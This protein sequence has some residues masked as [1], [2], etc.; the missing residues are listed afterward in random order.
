[1]L[2]PWKSAAAAA[3]ATLLISCG[4]GGGGGGGGGA[5]IG[6]LPPPTSGTPAPTPQPEPVASTYTTFALLPYRSVVVSFSKPN[7]GPG[8]SVEMRTLNAFKNAGGVGRDMAYDAKRDRLYI[9]MGTRI[10]MIPKA[11][12]AS[13]DV[14]KAQYDVLSSGLG[15][16]STMVLD[17]ERDELWLGGPMSRLHG[18]LVKISNISA[19]YGQIRTLES[20]GP[21]ET[22]P[23]ASYQVWYIRSSM[24]M[25]FAIDPTRSLVYTSDGIGGVF[26]LATLT[27]ARK[28]PTGD[29]VYEELVAERNAPVRMLFNGTNMFATDVALDV[30]RNRLYVLGGDGREIITINGASTAN[31]PGTFSRLPLS[32][33]NSSIAVDAKNDRLYV[34]GVDNNAYIFNNASTITAGTVVPGTSVLGAPESVAGKG[35]VWGISFP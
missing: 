29:P 30:A 17:A 28:E 33:V 13:G 22:R 23:V 1:M 6:L 2:N 25:R 15:S 31:S 7:P 8:E 3:L 35:V 11:S 5:G 27:P 34:G 24:L 18:A 19:A 12:Q 9:S 21:Q 14:T 4:G 16:F 32:T 10:L 20:I 26:D